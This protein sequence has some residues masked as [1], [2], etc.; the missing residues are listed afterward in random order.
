MITQAVILSI[1]PEWCQR[2]IT[3]EK[4][5]EV[6]KTRPKLLTPFKCY[7]YETGEYIPAFVQSHYAGRRKPG[8]I[9]GEFVCDEIREITTVFRNE[10]G[11]IITKCD[12][13]I[14]DHQLLPYCSCLSAKEICHYLGGIA[15]SGYGW[16][17]SKL[18]LYD[19]PKK[20]SRFYKLCH[21]ANDVGRCFEC[22]HACGEEMDCAKDYRV[23][24]KR[25][26]QSWCFVAGSDEKEGMK[27]EP[28]E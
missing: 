4:T 16:H 9:I 26:P 28:N 17:I 10:R 13:N 2:I 5:I 20:L 12:G 24:L 27:H 21:G 22:E 11:E 7:I 15:K 18:K 23:Y 6:R 8:G 19:K 1:R 3:G 14:W 25:P